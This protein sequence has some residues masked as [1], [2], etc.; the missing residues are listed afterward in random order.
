MKK[1]IIALMGLFTL[2]ACSEDAYDAEEQNAEMIAPPSFNNNASGFVN[3]PWGTKLP[4]KNY[5]SPWDIWHNR[6]FDDQQP[7]YYFNNGNV[8]NTSPYT[9]DVYAWVGLAY[10][11]TD[12]DGVFYDISIPTPGLP[13]QLIADMAGNPGSY[14]NLYPASNPHEVGNLV[15]VPL[16]IR[17]NPLDELRF[18]DKLDHLPTTNSNG[19]KYSSPVFNF[20]GTISTQEEDLLREYGKVFFYEVHVSEGGVS[21]GQYITH[22]EISTLPNFSPDGYWNPVMKSATQLT[23]NMPLLGGGGFPLYY[24][25]NPSVP[26]TVW[27]PNYYSS[28]N[29]QCD[30]HEVAFYLPPG[31]NLHSQ[32]IIGGSVSRTLGMGFNAHPFTVWQN[33]SLYLSVY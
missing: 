21:L 17:L 9:L 15:R 12:D 31:M 18:E 32:A 7:S 20:A 10:F 23:G 13:G 8:E 30:S 25:D 6:G 26:K 28:V 5:F 19:N 4:G 27:D 24:I 2:M 22:P 14:L 16:P 1:S 29:N 11:D 33:C 3:G